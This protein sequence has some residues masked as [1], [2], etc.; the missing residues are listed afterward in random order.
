[1]GNQEWTIQRHRGH[2]HSPQL[3]LIPYLHHMKRSGLTRGLPIGDIG[4]QDT[5]RGETK[6]KT[7][8]QK[9]KTISNTD[10][11]HIIWTV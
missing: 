8:I 11:T 4:T 9:T 2:W 7:T 6:H 1:M 10:P 3:R 5:G